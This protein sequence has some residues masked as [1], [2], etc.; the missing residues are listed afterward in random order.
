MTNGHCGTQHTLSDL[1]Q[2]FWIINGVST[3][4]RIIRKCHICR[5]QNQPSGNQIMAPLPTVRVSQEAHFTPFSAVGIDY[6]G[7]L[8]VS[9]S[10][11]TRSQ[12]PA[13]MK[14]YGCIFTCLKCRA[15][16]LELAKDLSTASFLNVLHRFIARRGPPQIIYSDNGTNFKGASTNVVAELKQLNQ[17]AIN[18]DLA[19]RKIEWRFSPPAAS[20]QGGI[21]ERLIR[22]VRKILFSLLQNRLVN[23]DT[24]HT[25]LCEIERILNDRPVTKLSQDINDYSTLT[26]NH[27]LLNR[28]NA[29]ISAL[30]S[31]NESTFYQH[32]WKQINEISELFW[33]RWR[34]QY[35]PMLQERQKWLQKRPNFKPGHLVLLVGN[36]PRGTW[37]K[38]II[39][40]VFP[41]SDGCTRAV[42]I[43]T[44]SG[45]FRRDIRKICML[46]E[47]LIQYQ[48]L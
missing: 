29:S 5:R 44:A 17:E 2:K 47:Q 19:I 1:R 42:L 6:F 45:T 23:E 38:G 21:W 13:L 27:L 15:I 43:R 3:V 20:H 8:H 31:S 28:R 11:R 4:R 46:E 25:A 16:H 22:S 40:D 32:S 41:G 33:T 10:V 36:T 39:S 48:N 26:P 14:R 18:N 24:L 12:N 30:E 35:L 9:K 7:P 37:P 34:K